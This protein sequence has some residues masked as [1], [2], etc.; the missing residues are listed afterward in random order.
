MAKISCMSF[1]SLIY[2][3][4]YFT[5]AMAGRRDVGKAQDVHVST[6]RG[7]ETTRRTLDCAKGFTS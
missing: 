3:S 7:G 4:E 6:R 5:F 2:L 1:P